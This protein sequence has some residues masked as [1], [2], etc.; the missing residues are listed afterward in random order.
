MNCPFSMFPQP[1]KTS[2]ST[3]QF[4]LSIPPLPQ[5]IL[6]TNT[7]VKTKTL[8]DEETYIYKTVK[9]RSWARYLAKMK[10]VKQN[11]AKPEKLIAALA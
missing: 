8:S 1:Q 2:I 4:N 7:S 5:Y 11:W 10:K 3:K 9:L 6:H